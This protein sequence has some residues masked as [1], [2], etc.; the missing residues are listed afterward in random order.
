MDEEILE[1]VA[2]N[3][4]TFEGDAVLTEEDA[5]DLI[6]IPR[7]PTADKEEPRRP[8]TSPAN[9]ARN[10]REQFKQ[11]GHLVEMSSEVG[12]R[13]LRDRSRCGIWLTCHR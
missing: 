7:P 5:Y 11:V 2:E 8:F 1:L 12:G 3:D 6:P 9:D 10:K 13:N 4:E